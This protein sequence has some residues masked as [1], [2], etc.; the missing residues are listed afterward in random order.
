MATENDCGCVTRQIIRQRCAPEEVEPGKRV[1]RCEKTVQTLRD[2]IGRPTEMI[3]S[4]TEITEHDMNEH[5]YHGLDISAEQSSSSSSGNWDRN[6]MQELD[7]AI[8]GVEKMT[9]IMEGVDRIMEGAEKITNSL[10]GFLSS[11]GEEREDRIR[12]VLSFP[13]NEEERKEGK[14]YEYSD[15]A[16]KIKDV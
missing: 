1:Y 6:L 9:E 4:Q 13:V 12:R 11:P 3:D 16:D 8:G 2:C 7:N 10:F 14:K 15:F 5:W